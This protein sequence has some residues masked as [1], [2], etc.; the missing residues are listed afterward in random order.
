MQKMLALQHEYV[1]RRIFQMHSIE[2]QKK[3]N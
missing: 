1:L 2:P 3:K